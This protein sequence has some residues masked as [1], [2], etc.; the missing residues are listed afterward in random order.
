MKYFFA[1]LFL[2]S[3]ATLF[4]QNS[5]IR[6]TTT[7]PLAS[8]SEEWNDVK[9]SGCNTA[10]NVTYMNEEEKN[11][12]YILNLVR[13]NPKLFAN[14]VLK[15]YPSLSGKDHLVHDSYYYQSLVTT[16]LTLEPKQML[17]PDNL[18]YSSA[19]CHAS[20]S[21]I[22]GYVGHERKRK[23]CKEKRYY[24]AECCDYGNSD[25]LEIVLNLL[26]DKGVPSL[27]HR[28]A[29]LANYSKIGVSIQPHSKYGANTVL[30][31]HY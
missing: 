22:S 16:L 10:A 18:C 1:I 14:T 13:T 5:S 31:F 2:I 3:S 20:T 28:D 26:I 6:I 25:A 29:C 8:Y 24:N 17:N 4:S 15:K 30:D 12:I 27:G 21:G 7:S 19:Q 23:D 9:Y 11:V